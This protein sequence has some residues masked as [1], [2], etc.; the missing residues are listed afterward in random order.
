VCRGQ[1]HRIWAPGGNPGDERR[2]YRSDPLPRQL[3]T[4]LR[5]GNAARKFA[6]LDSYVH[7]R[8]AIFASIKHGRHG[9]NWQRHYTWAWLRGLGVYRLSGRVRSGAAHAQR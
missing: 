6:Q 5:H 2:T 9:R 8:L 3:P 1:G 4:R 7:E